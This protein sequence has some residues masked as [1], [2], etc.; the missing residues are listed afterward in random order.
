MLP[1][2][3][4][5]LKAVILGLIPMFLTMSAVSA[6]TYYSLNSTARD[7]VQQ[8]DT[9][10][11]RMAAARLEENL[12]H[13]VKL[14]QNIA[15]DEAQ[16]FLKA[17]TLAPENRNIENLLYLFDGGIAVYD[18][19]G[20]MTWSYLKLL[21]LGRRFPVASKFEELRKT[22][23]PVFSNIFINPAI[24]EDVVFIG[25]PVVMADG[26]FMG[27]VIGM[28]TLRF[29][30]IG[31]MY[32]RVL[33][34]KSGQSAFA[35]LVDGEGRVI[36]HRHSSLIGQSL[37]ELEPVRRVIRG[38]AGAMVVN[39]RTN[40]EVISGFAPVPGTG[41]GIITQE[42]WRTVSG[43]IQS[44]IRL[45]WI[46]LWL[47]ALL[48]GVL[49]FVLISRLLLPI[50]ELTDGARR[51]AEGDFEQIPI[52]RTG[53]EIE[54]LSR[55]FNAMAKALQESFSRLEDRL[56]ELNRTQEALQE[57][58]EL[59]LHFM[60]HLPG[61][62]Y[63][64]DTA[65]RIVFANDLQRKLV[66]PTVEAESQNGDTEKWP[67]ELLTEIEVDRSIV[68][69]GSIQRLEE[70][71]DGPCGATNW[72]TYR[73]PIFYNEKP[74][75][76]GGIAIDITERKWA[77][78]ELEKHRSR[79]EELVEER[80]RD[81][82]AV[83]EELIKSEK[84]AVLGQLTATVSHE[85]RNPL[86][87]IRSSIYYLRRR[88][89]KIDEKSETH[90]ERIEQQVA[91]CDSI[92]NELLDYCR[93]RQPDL[94]FEQINP[95]IER[96]LDQVSLPDGITLVR[97]LSPALP[98]IPF[99]R[100]K[101]QQAVNNLLENAA[102]AVESMKK[103]QDANGSQYQPRISVRTR[104]ISN[105]VGIEVEDNGAGMDEATAA[106]A[107]EPLFTTRARGVGLGLAVV[108]KIVEDHR[109]TVMLNTSQDKGTII[110]LNIPLWRPSHRV[111]ADHDTK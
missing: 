8:R 75:F 61:R 34:F 90:L 15:F 46:L 100:N 84:L 99:D 6:I 31:T 88:Y 41:W 53:D 94:V 65:G 108:R 28:C 3:S 85:L 92:V 30:L 33:E 98:I 82:R 76:I 10:L 19:N 110:T 87:V 95:V 7:V 12:K 49:L 39:Q 62:A 9:E 22:Y 36:Y 25:V 83:Q 32:S 103:S 38:E 101:L 2:K 5:R 21:R 63:I 55:R 111:G 44:G 91:M 17:P 78:Q 45:S 93:M 27:A 35:Y 74:K 47:G 23:R 106:R 11:A 18:S 52:S 109:G 81:L 80:T 16:K 64:Q 43:P 50:R 71:L 104:A 67:P 107:F 37:S 20:Q 13:Y 54:T 96:V 97:E 14:L 26:T 105:G 86:G 40:D 60:K 48:S 79:L 69:V 77:E 72:L 56:T 59:F 58:R 29:S 89:P 4:L 24:H 68:Y 57:S 73:F 51:I 70:T 102:A 66:N 42:K 1:F